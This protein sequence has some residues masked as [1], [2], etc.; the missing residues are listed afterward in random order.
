MYYFL[1]LSLLSND[2]GMILR[3][4]FFLLIG[5][6]L[7]LCLMAVNLEA[8]LEILLTKVLFFWES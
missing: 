6:L 5:L 7:G 1:P 4:F 3:L 2:L 8:G